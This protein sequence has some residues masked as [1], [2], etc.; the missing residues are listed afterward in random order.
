MKLLAAPGKESQNKMVAKKQQ[1][2]EKVAC[3]DVKCPRHGNLRL[4]GRVFEGEV[5]SDRMQKTVVVQWVRQAHM[6]KY[7]RYYKLTS[8]VS[9][10]N[11]TCVGAKKGDFVRIAECRP[12]SK[13]VNFVVTEVLKQ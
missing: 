7:E 6:Q 2:E 4:H 13:T 8:K 12:L 10:R 9:A 1:K 11:P 5:V 3:N